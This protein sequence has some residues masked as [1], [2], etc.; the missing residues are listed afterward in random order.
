MLYNTRVTLNNTLDYLAN[1]LL[2][3]TLVC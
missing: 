3:R 1:E 2:T